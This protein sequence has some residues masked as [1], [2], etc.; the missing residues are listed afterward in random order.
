MNCYLVVIFWV[1]ALAFSAFYAWYA[2]TIHLTVAKDGNPKENDRERLF[3]QL[4]TWCSPRQSPPPHG[5]WWFHQVWLNF[6]GSLAGWAAAFYLVFYRLLSCKSRTAE[7]GLAD[8]FFV[9]LAL[10]GVTGLL[11]WRLSNTSLK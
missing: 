10:L 1:F 3:G 7:F 9:L 11:P 4:N 5:A 8:A 6:I 2:L